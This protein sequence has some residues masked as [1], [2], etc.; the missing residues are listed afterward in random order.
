MQPVG[1]SQLLITSTFQL[2][3]TRKVCVL[4]DHR[5]KST[6][7]LKSDDEKLIGMSMDY[8]GILGKKV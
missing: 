7:E 1:P 6:Y 8:I 3:I 4:F 5:L 2:S